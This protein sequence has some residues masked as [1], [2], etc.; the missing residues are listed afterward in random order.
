MEDYRSI[1]DVIKDILEVIPNEEEKIIHELK[2]YM[3]SLWN[4]A[5]E[6]LCT[7]YI[8][9]PVYNILNNNIENI[10]NEWKIQV[11]KIFNNEN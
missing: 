11:K 2:T 7:K 8:W 1:I 4:Q 5:P 9:L 6:A 3:K 10:N